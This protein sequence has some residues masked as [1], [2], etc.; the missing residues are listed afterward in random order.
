MSRSS[1]WSCH[2]DDRPDPADVTSQEDAMASGISTVVDPV[3]DLSQAKVIYSR[4]QEA[5]ATTRQEATDV[6]GGKLVATV[7]DADGNVIGL[8]QTS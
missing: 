4:L 7:T 3:K 8:T 2:Q 1:F 6:G 5:G